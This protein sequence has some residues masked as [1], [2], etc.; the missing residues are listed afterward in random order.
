MTHFHA[1]SRKRASPWRDYLTEDE[2]ETIRQA[3]A[4]RE[5]WNTLRDVRAGIISRATDR[6]RAA[7]AGE[8]D[9]GSEAG[10]GGG[11][12]AVCRRASRAPREHG[13]EPP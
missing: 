1:P 11:R 2:A 4:A 9:R 7:G 3:D 12:L 13:G 10:V 5:R 6:A 8:R